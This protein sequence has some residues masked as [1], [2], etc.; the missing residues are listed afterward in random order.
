MRPERQVRTLG[1]QRVKTRQGTGARSG[2]NGGAEE[3]FRRMVHDPEYPCLGARAALNAETLT[4]RLYGGLDDPAST[5]PLARD[6]AQFARAPETANSVYA[7]FVACFS[8]PEDLS[9]QAFEESLWR[10]LAEL[11]HLDTANWDTRVSAD[12]AEANFSFSFAG[13][14]FY[15]IGMHRR[16]SRPARSFPWP[17]LVFNPHEQF[18]RIREDGHWQSMQRVIRERDLQFSGRVNPTLS[19]FGTKSEARQY[20]GREVGD[21]WVPPVGSRGKC[22]FHQ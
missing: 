19:D 16:S 1:K 9:E 5:E 20:S 4:F 7:S 22:P 2:E 8:G 15:V 12:P 10:K 3:T 21:D 14:A 18:Q 11:H 13:Q 6:L 17:A